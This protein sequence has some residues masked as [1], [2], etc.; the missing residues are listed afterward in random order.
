M[1]AGSF[2]QKK[3]HAKVQDVL[4]PLKKCRGMQQVDKL[5]AGLLMI[6]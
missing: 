6:I 1:D 4:N 3:S 5:L 2:R